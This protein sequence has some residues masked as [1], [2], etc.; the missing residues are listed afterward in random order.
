MRKSFLG[1]LLLGLVIAL[2]QPACGG[3]GGGGSG[4]SS[5][6][7][8]DV[9]GLEIGE[10]MSLVT[11]Q[12]SGSSSLSRALRFLGAAGT[13]WANDE[14]EYYVWDDSM[15]VFDL[16]SEIMCFLGQTDHAAEGVVNAGPYTK[17]VD[18][19][20]CD[21]DADR[22]DE[23]SGQSSGQDQ[24]FEPWTVDS[25]RADESSPQVVK[26]WVGN[27]WGELQARMTIT[28]AASDSNPFGEFELHFSE[29]EMQ[30]F[31]VIAVTADGLIDLQM[32]IEDF[33][34]NEGVHAVVSL[35]D[36]RGDANIS[37]SFEG[38][39]W[40][41][42]DDEFGG[43][44]SEDIAVAYDADHFLSRRDGGESCKDRH[45]FDSYAWDYNVYD[46][47]YSRVDLSSGMPIR[48]PGAGDHDWGWAS[49]YGLWLDDIDIS[50]GMALTNEDETVDYT[51]F[52][53][54]GRLIRRTRHTLLLSTLI[55]ESFSYWQ[56]ASDQ[57]LQ[58]EVAAGTG[59]EVLLIQTGIESCGQ[60]GCQVTDTARTQLSFGADDFAGLW[61]DGFGFVELRASS[62]G[63]FLGS[64]DV[65]YHTEEF[66]LPGDAMFAGGAVT[67]KCYSSCLEVPTPTSMSDDDPYLP[68]DWTSTNPTANTFTFSPVD[69]TLRYNGTAVAIEQGSSI[70]EGTS[71]HWGVR[72]GGMVLSTVTLANWYNIHDEAVTYEWETGPNE[73]NQFTALMDASGDPVEFDRPLE[74]LASPPAI[75]DGLGTYRLQ[76]GGPGQLWGI[77]HEQ[78]G[79]GDDDDYERW[80]PLF[81]VEGEISCEGEVAYVKP[82]VIEQMMQEVAASACSGLS[83]DDVGPFTV[84]YTDP[85]I[86]DN[87]CSDTTCDV[88]E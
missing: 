15:E 51:A 18:V 57:N 81:T 72:S 76:Y 41:G 79:G 86:G 47:N 65:P 30:G 82:M 39:G 7:G 19:N 1:Y 14:T 60:D 77:P 20:A 38:G 8:T 71:N 6:G 87:P 21:H 58:V 42:E 17:L 37:R 26:L 70:L 28:A 23:G 61:K 64:M 5:S 16:V 12:E 48:V 63:K 34:W 66:V 29:S 69:F 11:A 40:E 31:I 24:A 62:Q 36:D 54:P 32:K 74:C 49:Y 73:W 25:T 43:S 59:D 78:K 85:D 56:W 52:V 55:G 88:H 3:G 35:D 53:A 4:G 67:F 2:L 80:V 9:E 33:G 45:S 10:Q 75:P 44:F 83:L 22:S 27:Q 50:H 13:D 84:E 68:F 46:I